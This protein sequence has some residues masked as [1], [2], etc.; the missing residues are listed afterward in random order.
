MNAAVLP[1]LMELGGAKVRSGRPAARPAAA[2]SAARRRAPAP[3][4]SG[5]Q[6]SAQEHERQHVIDDDGKL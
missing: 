2:A 1:E 3:G 5:G 4:A 6:I